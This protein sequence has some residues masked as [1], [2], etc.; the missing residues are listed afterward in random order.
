MISH[1]S[2][3]FIFSGKNQR[4]F[5]TS[6]ISKLWLRHSQE[7]KSKSFEMIMGRVCKP[8]EPKYLSW[9]RDSVATHSSLYSATKQSCWVE[10]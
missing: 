6:K 3:G 9:G 8:W 5:N 1:F 4:S 10:K 7:R 2:Y